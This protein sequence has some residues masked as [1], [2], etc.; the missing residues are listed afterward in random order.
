MMFQRTRVYEML[1]ELSPGPA[2]SLEKLPGCS[3]SDSE[4]CGCN[5]RLQGV[6]PV[7]T[8]RHGAAHDPIARPKWEADLSQMTMA[9]A[10]DL[11]RPG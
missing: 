1:L 4:M 11:A 3:Y 10:D 5:G 9:K 6:V 2:K 7:G 8:I